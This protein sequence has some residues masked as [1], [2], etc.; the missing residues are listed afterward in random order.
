M[1]WSLCFTLT[2][3]FF[4]T[5]TETEQQEEVP[6]YNDVM[7]PS[8]NEK[9]QNI[10]LAMSPLPASESPKPLRSSA[11]PVLNEEIVL[12]LEPNPESLELSFTMPQIQ[13]QPASPSD[14]STRQS[15]P[16]VG[17]MIQQNNLQSLTFR[18]VFVSL[19]QILIGAT[20]YCVE[21]G[22][23][24]HTHHCTCFQLKD[25][26]VGSSWLNSNRKGKFRFILSRF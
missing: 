12:K 11:D 22:G 13:D 5:D 4:P 20:C 3:A 23:E 8:S 14:G 26:N 1:S 21:V 15:S 24:T 7:F 25:R 19:I 10:N 16:E 18:N 2:N 17:I 9:V 6:L